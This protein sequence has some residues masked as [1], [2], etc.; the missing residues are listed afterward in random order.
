MKEKVLKEA[1]YVLNNNKTI[2]DAAKELSVSK[3]VLHRHL[4]YYLRKID[5]DMYL[6]IKNLFLEH[7]KVRH[8]HG[9]IATKNKYEGGYHKKGNSFFG[10]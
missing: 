9:G 1:L 3:S 10:K 6:K 4:S 7:N 2:R 5:Y 8:I